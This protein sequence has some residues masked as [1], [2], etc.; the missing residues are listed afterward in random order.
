[1]IHFFFDHCVSRRIAKALMDLH[2]DGPHYEIVSLEQYYQSDTTI[3]DPRQV[4]DEQWLSDLASDA[5]A[6]RQWNIVTYDLRIPKARAAKAVWREAGLTTFFLVG[7]GNKPFTGQA[8]WLSVNWDGMVAAARGNPAGS[9]FKVFYDSK[10][11][12]SISW[13][14]R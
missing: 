7:F 9:A 2:E 8:G 14:V 4:K 11:I 1:M 10:K 6:G 12:H 5:R 13:D 3:P